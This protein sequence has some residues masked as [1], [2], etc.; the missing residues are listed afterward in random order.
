MEGTERIRLP[1]EPPFHPIVDLSAGYEVLDLSKGGN[2]ERATDSLCTVGRYDEDRSI[3]T[4]ALFSGGRS[5]HMGIDIGAPAGTPVFAFE[6]GAVSC[7]G[8]NDAEGDYGPTIITQH[9][10]RGRDLWVLHGHLS[11]ESL[12][13]RRPGDLIEP[14][15]ILGWLGTP[16]VNGGWPPHVHIQLSV[17]RPLTHDM[18]GAVSP[19]QRAQALVCYPDPRTILGPLY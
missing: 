4:A 18:P 7:Q 10:V 17:E 6:R 12:E 19:A 8:I 13:L 1:P 9:L 11:A 3:Y 14:G 15:E 2:S 16:E 5:V